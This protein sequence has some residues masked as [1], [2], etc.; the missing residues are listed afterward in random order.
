MP[1]ANR[2]FEIN[3]IPQQAIPLRAIQSPYLV[4]VTYIANAVA[5]GVALL[6]VRGSL[7][8]TV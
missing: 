7:R 2:W 6:L 8:G 3:Y 1:K 4:F 5:L